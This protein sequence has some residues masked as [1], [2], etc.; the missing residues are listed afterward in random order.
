MLLSGVQFKKKYIED[1]FVKLTN[2]EDEKTLKTGLN[3]CNDKI[4]PIDGFAQDGIQLNHMLQIPSVMNGKKYTRM[5]KILDDSK[6]VA[7]KKFFKTN[8]IILREKVPIEDFWL[9]KNQKLCSKYVSESPEI[10]QFIDNQTDEMCRRAVKKKSCVIA[11]VINQTDELC[12][13]ALSD[14]E[15]K[16]HILKSIKNPTFE[17]C[18]Y[19]VSIVPWE[20]AFI[21]KW[22]DFSKNQKKELIMTAMFKDPSI[23]SFIETDMPDDFYEEIVGKYPVSIRYIEQN[24]KLCMIAVEIDG[25][26]IRYVKDQTFNVCL[27]AVTNNGNSLKYID[28]KKFEDEEVQFL[29]NEAVSNF[30]LAIE[31]VPSANITIEIC[32][33]AVKQF[34][35][36]LK[37]MWDSDKTLDIGRA[38]AAVNGYSIRYFRLETDEISLIAVKECGMALKY[39]EYQTNEICLAAVRENGNALQHIKFQTLQICREAIKQ[40]KYAINYVEDEFIDLLETDIDAKSIGIGIE[41]INVLSTS[42]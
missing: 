2:D 40:T 41:E 29:C 15:R 36:A 34:R 20:I 10:L 13:L 42:Y 32:V 18:K 17:L 5:I 21:K 16:E 23:A 26:L 8:K 37:Y 38:V 4:L 1:D 14:S 12:R 7:G 27:K 35:Y 9:W 31:Y 11:W 24:N 39:V 33:D 25:N 19:A 30:G 3:I 28:L 6:V 22:D